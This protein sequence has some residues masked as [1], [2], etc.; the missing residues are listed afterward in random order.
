MMGEWIVAFSLVMYQGAGDVRREIP[1]NLIFYSV[2]DCQWYAR[3][4]ARQYG[5]Y[6][7]V[8][9]IPAKDRL[10]TYCLPKAV[11]PSK[12]KVF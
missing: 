1:T 5:N 9:L 11:D 7:Y 6:K 2:S 8:D 3:Q 12:T 10:T 4:L